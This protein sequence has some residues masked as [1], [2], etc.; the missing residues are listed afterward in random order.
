MDIKA[1]IRNPDQLKE[2]IEIAKLKD[3]RY[4]GIIWAIHKYK[5][6]NWYQNL[7]IKMDS[8]MDL[9]NTEIFFNLEQT[10]PE[11]HQDVELNISFEIENLKND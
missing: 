11:I 10:Y 3:A 8:P 2:A 7:H 6:Y 4:T 5:W 1:G 9:E